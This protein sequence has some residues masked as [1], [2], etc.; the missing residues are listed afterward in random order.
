[1]LVTTKIGNDFSGTT[2]MF[3]TCLQF[4][5]IEKGKKKKQMAPGLLSGLRYKNLNNRYMFNVDKT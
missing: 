4:R 2:S 3:I 1:M 5:A